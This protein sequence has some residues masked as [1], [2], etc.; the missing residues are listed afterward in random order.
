MSQIWAL[1]L[2]LAFGLKSLSS[3]TKS[4]RVSRSKKV[5]DAKSKRKSGGRY[6]FVLERGGKC[7][8]E[9]W[10]L[11][12]LVKMERRRADAAVAEVERE[13]AASATAAEEAMGMIQRLQREKNSIQMGYNQHRR[14]CEAR[15]VHDEEV[16]QSLE[17]VLWRREA[18]L[19][20][21]RQHTRAI[22]YFTSTTMY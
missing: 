17:W 15:D 6:D 12:K 8:S 5:V 22:S 7:G 10:A 3:P 19:R 16:I 2:L 14:L 11:R 13:R 9:V 18:E 21:L 20:L 1:F 4:S